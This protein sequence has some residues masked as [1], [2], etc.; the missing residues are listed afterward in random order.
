MRVLID[1]N[2]LL[3][4]FGQRE[5]FQIP[6]LKIVALAEKKQFQ[7]LVAAISF[8]NVYYILRKAAGR[9]NALEALR[10][11]HALFETVPLNG[12]TIQQA[13]D[14]DI[15][16]FEDA[17]QYYSAVRSRAKCLITRDPRHYPQDGP[18]ILSPETFLA[19]LPEKPKKRTA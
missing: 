16:D 4:F 5:P 14:S 6:A 13:L 1:T 8:N 9:K 15:V 11:M 7:A 17:L 3:D 19:R 12:A 2:V 10:I 18:A